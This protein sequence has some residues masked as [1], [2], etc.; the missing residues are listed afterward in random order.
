MMADSFHSDVIAADLQTGEVD[1]DRIDATRSIPPSSLPWHVRFGLSWSTGAVPVVLILLLGVALGPEGLAIITPGVLVVLDPVIPV[2]V[3][4]LGILAGLELMRPAAPNRWSLLHKASIE[5]FATGVLVALGVWLIMPAPPDL[6]TSRVWLI[7]VLAGVCASMSATLPDA[8]PDRL[9]PPAIRMRDLDGLLP[10][11][12]G[13]VV[14]A[15]LHSYSPVA[16]LGL[17]IQAAILALLISATAWLLLADSVPSTE[18]RVFSIAALLL[19][20]GIADYLS[21]SALVGGLLAGLFWGYVGGVARDCIERDVRYLRHPLVVLM[22][23]TA[24]A[25]TT[26]S[27]WI[28]LLALAYLLLRVTGKLVGAWLVR[29]APG[30]VIPERVASAL[31]PPGI[32]GIAFALD[33]ST[34]MDGSATAI[35]SAAVLGSIGSQLVAALW[36]PSELHE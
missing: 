13:A 9:R 6:D 16:S 11:V 29:R 17:T 30:V 5:S 23:L 21:L 35:L 3:A 14:L 36:R 7:A 4:A 12:V 8:D 26:F 15:F 18:Q 31:L 22:L 2:A 27:V 20:G 10:A 1:I 32:F 33:A 28:L 19:V 24:G 34:M 25:K